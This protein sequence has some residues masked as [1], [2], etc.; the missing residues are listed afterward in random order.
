METDRNWLNLAAELRETPAP[1]TVYITGECNSGKSTLSHY[2]VE[3][4]GKF[5]V[6]YLDCDPGQSQIGPPGTLGLK[7]LSKR[8]DL[9]QQ[10]FLRFVGST[11]PASNILQNLSSIKRLQEKAFE[12]KVQKLIIDSSGFVQGKLAREYQFQVIDLIRPDI[13]VVLMKEKSVNPLFRNF[14]GTPQIN[15]LRFNVS[16]SAVS[17]TPPERRAYREESFSKYFR[18]ATSREISFKR[19][20]LHGRIPLIHHYETWKNLLIALC[21]S[22]NFALC[23]G[24]VE[25]IELQTNTIRFLAPSFDREAVCAI[26]FGSLYLDRSGKELSPQSTSEPEA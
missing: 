15:V 23:L 20:G 18:D 10:K 19:I 7:I 1:Q 3:E 14:L 13:V 12:Q 24:I 22:E 5:S 6:S 9:A 17:R 8:G 26:Q 4:L 16:R 21:D 25:H 11:S 2:L